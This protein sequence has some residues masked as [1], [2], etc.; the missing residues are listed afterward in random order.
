MPIE[1]ILSLGAAFIY[2]ICMVFIKESLRQGAGILRSTF[3]LH[4]VMALVFLPLLFI[5]ATI[6]P[7]GSWLAP[8]AV[9][10]SVFLGQ[11]FI[12]W[13]LKFGDPSVQTPVMGVKSTMVAIFV[14][15]IAGGHIPL[16]WWAAGLLS[17]LA[18]Y[19]LSY[20][21]GS[22]L[23]K[24]S[25]TWTIILTFLGASFLGLGD[26]IMEKYAA[27]FGEI[28]FLVVSVLSCALASLALVP[29][30]EGPLLAMPKAS[31][32]W[33]LWGSTLYGLEAIAFYI[34]ISFYG[35]ATAIN[36][37]YSSRGLWSIFVV[38]AMGYFFSYKPNP[39]SS[40]VLMRRGI[41]TLLLFIAILLIIFAH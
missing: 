17:L 14:C 8:I 31:I 11:I 2:A 41:G 37:L 25:N 27:S 16:L 35:Q 34:A 12:L 38:W 24:I 4:W 13:A 19:F 21:E 28:P 29:F 20:A 30:F 3:I 23:L 22:T 1:Y 9:G 36:V 32:K 33:A 7:E 40:A 18:I 6:L 39:I 10:L 26:V 5:N 15:F